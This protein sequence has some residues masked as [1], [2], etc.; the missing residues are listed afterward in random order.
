[1]LFPFKITIPKNTL[2]S[3]PKRQTFSLFRGVITHI[4]VAFPFGCC[5]LVGIKLRRFGVPFF[6]CGGDEWFIANGIDRR[7]TCLLDLRDEPWQV[8]FEGYNEDDTYDHTVIVRIECV[9]PWQLNPFS[10]EYYFLS[11]D[12]PFRVT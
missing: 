2:P 10:D 5:F 4:D 1:M 11:H 9:R 7:Y 3:N 6:P 12:Y 8:E